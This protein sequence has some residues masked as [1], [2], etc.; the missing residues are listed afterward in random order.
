MSDIEQ[1]QKT[2][3]PTGK[4]LGDARN[5]GQLPISREVTT[6]VSL[7][8]ILTVVAWALPSLMREMLSFLRIFLEQPESF[9]LDI[10]SLQSLFFS[11]AAHVGMMIGL[12]LLILMAGII[13]GVMV[14][15][16]FF[17]ELTLL[18]VDL[19]RLLPTQ[20]FKKLFSISAIVDIIKS[21]AKMAFLGGV[22]LA[23]LAPTAFHAPG[24]TGFPLEKIL[25]FLHEKIQHL[26]E[27]LLLVFTTIAI[28]DYYFTNFQYI[29]NLRMTKTEVKDENKQQEGDPMIKMRLRQ[30]RF[31]KARKRM[32]AQVPKA[33]V[34]IT[35]P[36]H[37]A[38]ALKYDSA[39]MA[40]PVVLAK[41]LNMIAER[42]REVALENQVP[43]VSNPPL[44]RALHDTVEVD[45]PIPTQHYRAVA[46]V[47]SYVY[48]LRKRKF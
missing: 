20:G 33:D 6:W 1:D 38:V 11:A 7:L 8:S 23:V 15:T 24:L 45:H 35:N 14:Q 29:K 30:I 21:L 37:Y 36:T 3:Q 47:I 34:V 2:E 12:A 42:I 28:G 32:M 25:G 48:K 44:A 5:Q 27:M 19:M 16:G 22:A 41:G 40:A 10:E 31:D 9:A 18:K 17:F 46:E 13:G 43:L 39:K 4:R 26:I